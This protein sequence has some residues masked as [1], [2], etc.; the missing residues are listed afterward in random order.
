MTL[1]IQ[2]VIAIIVYIALR[3]SDYC[4]DQFQNEKLLPVEARNEEKIK[5][6]KLLYKIFNSIMWIGVAYF[7]YSVITTIP[8]YTAGN[9]IV[10]FIKTVVFSLI[11]CAVMCYEEDESEKSSDDFI[12]YMIVP[13]FA[14]LFLSAGMLV[15]YAVRENEKEKNITVIEEIKYSKQEYKLLN[16]FYSNIPEEF[17][18]V[19]NSIS[20]YFNYEAVR[21]NGKITSRTYQIC[22][23]IETKEKSE[24]IFKEL[25]GENTILVPLKKGE[26]P[27]LE[28]KTYIQNG[29]DNSQDP[30]Q[31]IVISEEIENILH[32]SQEDIN[33]VLEED[34]KITE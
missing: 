18:V 5:K 4:I 29:I 9:L 12:L 31:N 13:I 22:Y 16:E 28:I 34:K 15:D 6:Y 1:F 32:V 23:L 17:D 2:I 30:P 19:K 24:M 7:L 33:K 11:G 26:E 21:F 20:E 14:C 10:A 25:D 27:Y 8:E 3:F